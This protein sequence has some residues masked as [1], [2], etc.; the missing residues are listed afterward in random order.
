MFLHPAIKDPGGKTTGLFESLQKYI[1]GLVYMFDCFMFIHQTQPIPLFGGI[2]GSY[3]D[4]SVLIPQCVQN[5][6][7]HQR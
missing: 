1:S 6:P 2:P 3:A 4:S 5:E 7:N